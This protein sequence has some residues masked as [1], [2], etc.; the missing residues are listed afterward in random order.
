MLES[1]LLGRG[2]PLKRVLCL[3]AHCDD[4]EIG[5]GG[6]LLKLLGARADSDWT[7][8]EDDAEGEPESA[9]AGPSGEPRPLFRPDA[10]VSS[11]SRAGG[12]VRTAEPPPPEASDL[13]VTWVVFSSNEARAAE[14]RKGAHLFLEGAAR[15]NVVVHGFRDGFLPHHWAEVKDAFERLKRETAPD[16]I[17]THYRHDLHQDHRIVSELTWNTFRDHLILE[18]EIPKYEGDLGAP[19]AFTHLDETVARRKAAGI[20]ECYRSQAG[21]SWF[22]EETFLSLMRI[23]GVES[24]APG[25][26]A[27]AFHCRKL[28]LA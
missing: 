3:G 5:C 24:N 4:I 1:G 23:R 16:L 6:T 10:A 20:L 27:E 2:R 19:N 17:F 14:A 11:R 9:E 21:H 8:A 22:T 26:F 25:R 28:L 12:P 18:Y 13:E 15:R 7:G